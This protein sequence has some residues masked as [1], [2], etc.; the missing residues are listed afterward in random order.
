MAKIQ[1]GM[2]FGGGVSSISKSF[3]TLPAIGSRICVS[4]AVWANSLGN[5]I[6][7]S[8]NQG[9]TYEMKWGVDLAGNINAYAF[10]HCVVTTSSGTFTVTAD[11]GTSADFAIVIDELS[12][13]DSVDVFVNDSSQFSAVVTAS[14]NIVTTR[15]NCQII[16]MMTHAWA[17]NP[18]DVVEG[19]GFTLD[20]EQTNNNTGAALHVAYRTAPTAGTY[21]PSW[22]WNDSGTHDAVIGII[23]Y[24]GSGGE[25][26][27]PPTASVVG[28]RRLG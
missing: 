24:Y 13:A 22:T 25:Q 9:N 18:A 1:S 14:K 5:N 21:T 3:T 28:I 20:Q 26:Q 15:D 19:G 27:A 7:V 6:V 23:A 16:A 10:G 17:N 12:D 4:I 8:D 2:A 11:A